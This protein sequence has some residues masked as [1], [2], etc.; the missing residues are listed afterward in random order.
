LYIVDVSI[1]TNKYLKNILLYLLFTVCSLQT[2]T[3]QS[4][5]QMPTSNA[6]WEIDFWIGPGYPHYYWYYFM[7]AG[8]NDTI[9]NSNTY[10]K[11]YQSSYYNLDIT[12]KGGLRENN[13]S[14]VFFIPKDSINE[15]LLADYN[16]NVGDTALHVYREFSWPP[17]TLIVTYKDSNL[18]A[19]RYIRKLQLSNGGVW[20]EGIGRY[21][22]LFDMEGSSV[23]GSTSLLCMDHNDTMWYE[24]NFTPGP[25][26]SLMGIK[27]KIEINTIIISPNPAHNQIT[28][29]LNEFKVQSAEL[30]V[31]DIMGQQVMEEKIYSPVSTFNFQLSSG[32]YFV[33]VGEGQKIAVQKLVI[34]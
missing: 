30:K 19:N 16:L 6:H 2:T 7:S 12:Y 1:Q 31:F 17:D 27:E 3:A 13:S 15:L 9:I 8:N 33:K 22:G 5:L 11:V 20:V 32:V 23:S 24:S 28:I 29:S 21:S 18:V 10:A 34:Q 26:D 4:Y 14:Q 25:C